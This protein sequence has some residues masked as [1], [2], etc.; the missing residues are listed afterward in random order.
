MQTITRNDENPIGILDIAFLEFTLPLTKDSKEDP[1][2]KN[3]FQDTFAFQPIASH[4]QQPIDLY[5]QGKIDFIINYAGMSFART[6]STNHGPSVC[7]M[8]LKTIDAKTAFNEAVKRGAK[9]F[10][11]TKYNS[12]GFPTIYGIGD[13]LIYF[14][15]DKSLSYLYK[16]QF[17]ENKQVL[18][19]DF[20]L[21]KI[22]HLTNNV[23]QGDLIKWQKFYESI[24]NFRETRYFDIKGKKTGL[25]S[26]V[27]TSPGGTVTI[28][29]NEP[30]D[31]KSQ[32]QEYLDEYK[33]EGIQHI[34]LKTSDLIQ[35]VT[36]LKNAGVEF[37]DVPDTYYEVLLERIP[38]VTEDINTLKDL[39]IL[40]DGDSEGY[41]LQIFTQNVIGPIF[42]EIIQRKNHDG[43]G[44]GNFQAL[45]DAIERDQKRRGYL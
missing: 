17:K 21:K 29:I 25:I 45:F 22:D 40:V 32:I 4:K 41:L 8:G 44:E 10:N 35:S 23:Y 33:G 15:D 42:F 1:L 20:G 24:F 5:R 7:G 39:K 31:K 43:F 34:A 6:F 14:V 13:S 30:S 36:C 28:P 12:Y 2:I 18:T 3:L 16:N 37:L 11:D 38:Q 19:K 27:M 26:K 9:P